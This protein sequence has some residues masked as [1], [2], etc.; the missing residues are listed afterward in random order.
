[1]VLLLSLIAPEAHLRFLEKKNCKLYLRPVE[2]AAPVDEIL[3]TV[4]DVVII[5]VPSSEEFLRDE[6]AVPVVYGKTWGE[7][8]DDPW[9]VYHTSGTTGNLK[10]VTYTH[11]MCA[12]FE[13]A[14][15]LPDVEENYLH[16]YA[17]RRCLAMTG[18]VHMT[19]VFGPPSSPSPELL[20]EI[21]RH[22]KIDGAQLLP[23]L[24]DALW[25]S[26]KGRQ[27]LCQLK[28]VHYAGAPLSRKS[29][30]FLAQHTHLVPCIGSTESGGYFTVLHDK[31]DA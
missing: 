5:T 1:M 14:A 8:K 13:V 11:R 4:E 29:E 15:T 17:Q 2:M 24:I 21:F 16:Q 23:S 3:K 27:A 18:F 10:A 12:G 31:K 20:V 22:G 19:S 25:L 30:D 9:L 28:Y 6:E 26:P 7:G